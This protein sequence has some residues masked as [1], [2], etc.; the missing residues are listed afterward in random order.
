MVYNKNLQLW[1]ADLVHNSDLS[2]TVTGLKEFEE[3]YTYV[4]EARN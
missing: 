4:V 2:E 1:L 3:T